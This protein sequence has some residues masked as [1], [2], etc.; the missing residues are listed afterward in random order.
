[1]I[2]GPRVA[3]SFAISFALFA[4]VQAGQPSDG[5]VNVLYKRAGDIRAPDF[6]RDGVADG[7]DNCLRIVNPLQIDTNSDS[8]GNL[9]DA[10]FNNDC[11]VNFLDLA[12]AKDALFAMPGN[13]NWNPDT[14]LNS[15]DVT[16]FIDLEIIK[17]AFFSTPGPSGIDNICSDPG[18][19]LD[20]ALDTPDPDPC[21]AIA[22]WTAYERGN[23][24]AAEL[25]KGEYLHLRALKGCRSDAVGHFGRPN[26]TAVR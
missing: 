10:D 3:V 16:D 14:D 5:A 15:D 21:D 22:S 13:G 26:P 4:T 23:L 17:G 11:G 7:V 18:H 25:R 24:R 1:M 19:P 12:I 6:D 8:I 2:S 9:C 20:D